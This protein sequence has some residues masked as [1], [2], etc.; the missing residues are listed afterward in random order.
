MAVT[1][2]VPTAPTST[3]V[4]TFPLSSVSTEQLGARR[5]TWS[6]LRHC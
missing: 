3:R 5:C 6:E 4:A 2:L 1:V